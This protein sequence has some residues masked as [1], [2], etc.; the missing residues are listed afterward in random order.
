M[1]RDHPPH[2]KRFGA[3]AAAPRIPKDEV[4]PLRGRRSRLQFPASPGLR[5]PPGVEASFLLVRICAR[6]WSEPITA[7]VLYPPPG[8]LRTGNDLDLVPGEEGG[9]AH[10]W[11]IDR[12]IGA[13]LGPAPSGARARKKRVDA[14]GGGDESEAALPPP[15]PP[16]PPPRRRTEDRLPLVTS[17]QMYFCH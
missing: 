3:T 17:L 5:P 1:G 8:D 4:F 10:E 12:P 11:Q 14:G 15:S 16:P 2:A 9:A 7:S 13:A 6:L